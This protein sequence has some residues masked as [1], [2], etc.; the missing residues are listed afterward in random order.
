M[1]ANIPQTAVPPGVEKLG[2][3]VDSSESLDLVVSSV[4]LVVE[5]CVLPSI[6]SNKKSLLVGN[7]NV[8]LL[9]S[10]L[11]AKADPLSVLLSILY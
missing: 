4:C 10:P 2:C 3:F 7:G 6:E 9:P 5:D 1:Y 8:L 11:V